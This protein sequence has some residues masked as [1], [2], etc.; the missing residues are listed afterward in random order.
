M[1]GFSNVLATL[2]LI[3]V[4]G[5][6][7]ANSFGLFDISEL[8]FGSEFLS[9]AIGAVMLLLGLI[10]ICVAVQSVRPEQAISIQNPEGEVRITFGAV[11]ELLRKVSRRIDGVKELKPK[12]VVGKKGLEIFTRISVDASVSIPQVTVK[13]QDM[14]KSQV[15]GVL[16]IEE[17]AA[18]RIYIN[19]IVT[20]EGSEEEGNKEKDAK[21]S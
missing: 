12:V 18:I 13:I 7:L 5:G 1:R 11:E 20:E 16:G 6:L 3:V 8:L 21:F 14:V 10:V 19:R 2:L 9:G 15:K 17:I 4:G